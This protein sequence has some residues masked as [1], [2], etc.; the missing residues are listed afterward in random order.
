M[1]KRGLCLALILAL[2]CTA[3]TEQPAY[4]K[5]SATIYDV[6]D[7]AVTVIAYTRDEAEFEDAVAYT[8]ERLESL[9]RLFDNYNAYDGVVNVYT[10]NQ[11]AALAP[12]AVSPELMELLLFARQWQP[13]V[14]N[15]V[16]IAMGTVLELWHDA[17][18]HANDGE[19][20]VLPSQE[21]LQAAAAH[22]DFDSLVLD[23]KNH[24]VY[25]A[26]PTMKL[27]LGAVAKGFATEKVSQELL[28]RGLTSF[29][30]NAGG[31]VR[32]G[33]RPMDGRETWA[34]S[35]QNPN[36]PASD[37]WPEILYL[38]DLSVVTSGDYQR[39][40]EVDGVR[41][42]HIIS[43]DTLYPAT[44]NRSVTIVTQDSALADLLS[45]AVFLLPYEQGRALVDSLDGVE[46]LWITQEGAI[47]RTHGLLPYC[48]SQKN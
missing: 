41:Y 2:L 25:Y 23:E 10:L 39:Y 31:N 36:D 11:Q 30:L 8:R 37:E 43:P 9:N 24:T 32:V 29:I 21:S 3:C 1:R 20:T 45:T 47:Y 34:V 35:I 12:V 22:T 33:G 46:A 18:E 28:A 13:R 6:F 44:E 38:N 19:T 16:N 7:T 5:Y 17:R 14:N 15:R 48:A 4:H 42:H 27:D 26:D 40:F